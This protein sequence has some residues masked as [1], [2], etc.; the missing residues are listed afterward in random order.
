VIGTDSAAWQIVVKR[1]EPRMAIVHH[2][3]ERGCWSTRGR[4]VL[5]ARDSASGWQSVAEFPGQMGRDRLARS[6]LLC[7]ALRLDRCNVYPTRAGELMGIHAG[8]VWRLTN[9]SAEPLFRIRG[10]SLM[11][12]AI[13]EDASGTIY[14]GEYDANPRREPV[15]LWRV[16]A[17]LVHFDVAYTFARPRCRHVHALHC[18]P[19]RPERIWITMGDFADE[20]FLGWT[21][22]GFRHVEFLGDGSQTFR[23][24]GLVFQ[25]DRLR[26]LTDSHLV[27]NRSVSLERETGRVEQHEA[28]VSSSWY[29]A[30]TT[31]GIHLATTTVE[32][33][34]AIHSRRCFLLASDDGVTWREVASFAKDRWPMRLFKFGSL[35]LPSG[36]FSSQEIWLSGEGVEGLEGASIL[37]SLKDSA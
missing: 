28:V 5:H 24:V 9:G 7:R 13:A 36:R 16:S 19:Y 22:D 31:D 27:Q 17:D 33:G 2:V 12:R 14:F 23:T 25:K 37:C 1:R 10:D 32:P 20:C 26:W 30:R 21:D 15:R 4:E 6:R 11:N 29:A 3:D 18:D 8:T 34:P 35:S